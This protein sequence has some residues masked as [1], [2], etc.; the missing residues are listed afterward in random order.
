MLI[1]IVYIFD[2]YIAKKTIGF[3]GYKITYHSFL[4]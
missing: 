1:S 4:T 2:I 3:I